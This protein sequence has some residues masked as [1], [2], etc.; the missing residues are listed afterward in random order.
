MAIYLNIIPHV[1][2]LKRFSSFTASTIAKAPFNR[3]FSGNGYCEIHH[4]VYAHSSNTYFPPFPCINCL[5]HL[6]INANKQIAR[7]FWQTCMEYWLW[8]QSPTKEDMC[9]EM[10]SSIISHLSSS[11]SSFLLRAN[12]ILHNLYNFSS[13]KL[14]KKKKRGNGQ[15]CHHTKVCQSK[16]GAYDI[17][18]F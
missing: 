10:N 6:R 7:Y 2:F 11:V 5:K 14:Q 1:L 8:S 17:C 18:N 4:T 3:D 13:L 12:K 9:A 16:S 15:I